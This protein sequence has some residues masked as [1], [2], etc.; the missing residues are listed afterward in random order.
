MQYVPS[1][2]KRYQKYPSTKILKHV[3]VLAKIDKS[4]YGRLQKMMPQDALQ[5]STSLM[6]NEPSEHQSQ[7]KGKVLLLNK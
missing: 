4:P 1:F 2:Q 5:F 6:Y 7:K 3:N